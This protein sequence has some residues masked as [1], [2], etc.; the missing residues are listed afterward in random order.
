MQIPKIDAFQEL[1]PVLPICVAFITYPVFVYY[2]YALGE[3]KERAD[4][5]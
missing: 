5:V 3:S 4:Q 2:A 1:L